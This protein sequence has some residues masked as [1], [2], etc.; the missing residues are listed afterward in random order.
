MLPGAAAVPSAFTELSLPVTSD[1]WMVTSENGTAP[2]VSVGELGAGLRLTFPRPAKDDV[3][4]LTLKKPVAMPANA[5]R[6]GLWCYTAGRFWGG[7]GSPMAFLVRD[8]T[9]INY[10]YQ[11]YGSAPVAG[12]WNYVECP[13]FRAGELGRMDEVLVHV[14]GGLQHHLPVAPLQFVGV[15]FSLGS[16][17][18][19]PAKETIELGRVCADGVVRE[20]SSLYWQCSLGDRYLF[21]EM[22]FAQRPFITAGDILTV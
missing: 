18:W 15:S 7:E 1:A 12:T 3:I 11:A 2:T 22:P 6:V 16:A 8:A 19:I 5:R 10:T 21:G 13:R 9:G 4:T 14:E 20:K 17:N